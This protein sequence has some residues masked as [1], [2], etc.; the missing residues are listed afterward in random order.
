MYRPCTCDT[1]CIS[2]LGTRL[3]QALCSTWHHAPYIYTQRDIIEGTLMAQGKLVDQLMD[4]GTG[5]LG[6]LAKW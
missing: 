3:T 1:A 6:I 5:E 2:S 4:E